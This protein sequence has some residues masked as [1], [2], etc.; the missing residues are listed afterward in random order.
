MGWGNCGAEV[1]RGLGAKTRFAEM[2]ARKGAEK[3]G[4]ALGDDCWRSKKAFSIEEKN[5]KKDWGGGEKR[6]PAEKKGAAA[7]S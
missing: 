1:E 4:G 7:H 6:K 2:G 5:M 3:K